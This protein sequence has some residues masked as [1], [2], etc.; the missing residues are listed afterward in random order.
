MYAFYLLGFMIVS[1][2]NDLHIAS[3]SSAWELMEWLLKEW[4]S[5]E[6]I[7]SIWLLFENFPLSLYQ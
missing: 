6:S 7:C 5:I 4:T 2:F 1:S 3:D